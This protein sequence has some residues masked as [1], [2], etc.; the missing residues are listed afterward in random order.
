[1]SEVAP[2]SGRSM[3][4][5]A[6]VP[7]YC[8]LDKWS[9]D[10]RYTEGRCPICGWA[11]E[12]APTAPAWLRRARKF[13]WELTGLMVLLVVLV[14]LAAVVAHA[15]G[16]R[17]PILGSPAQA[18]PAAAA[19]SARTG[20]PSPSPSHSPAKGSPSPSPKH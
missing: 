10:P 20:N 16:Y 3:S 15:A 1:M 14:V 4:A 7:C 18:A 8:E 9:F 11:P 2:A 12:G 17:I 19:S 6:P 5:R 13:E